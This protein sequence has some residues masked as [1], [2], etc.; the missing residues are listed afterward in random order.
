MG[1][2]S[3]KNQRSSGANMMFTEFMSYT[4]SKDLGKS[5]NLS[6]LHMTINNHHGLGYR[7]ISLATDTIYRG[8]ATCLFQFAT[9]TLSL[10]CTFATYTFATYTCS[11]PN[12][13]ATCY[14]RYLNTYRVLTRILKIGVKCC[15]PEKSWSFTILIYCDFLKG[16]SQK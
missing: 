8:F 1:V 4:V 2:Q 3:H 9:Y 16:W 13:F 7:L 5:R 14:V 11:L 6:I 10:P 12:Y 15:P